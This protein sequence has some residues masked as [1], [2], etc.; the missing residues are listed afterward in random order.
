MSNEDIKMNLWIQII[1]EA[2]NVVRLGGGHYKFATYENYIKERQ[3]DGTY[4]TEYIKTGNKFRNYVGD[5]RRT[6]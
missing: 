5:N 2:K 3:A 6:K 4:K 1:K